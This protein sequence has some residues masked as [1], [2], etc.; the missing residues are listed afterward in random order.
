M[1]LTALPDS[2]QDELDKLEQLLKV[3]LEITQKGYNKRAH[4]VLGLYGP[5]EVAVSPTPV[6]CP[7]NFPILSTYSPVR[8][9]LRW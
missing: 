3:D 1:N 7:R 9:R 6:C 5:V 8:N 2:V 4:A